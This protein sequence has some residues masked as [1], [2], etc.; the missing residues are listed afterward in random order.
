MVL[1]TI[2]VTEYYSYLYVKSERA[3]YT[4]VWGT[5][6]PFAT[7]KAEYH[8]LYKL[9]EGKKELIE[10][11]LTIREVPGWELTLK[12][13]YLT[14]LI[15]DGDMRLEP[16]YQ[17]MLCSQR[18]TIASIDSRSSRDTQD[19]YSLAAHRVKRGYKGWESISVAVQ[20]LTALPDGQP[21]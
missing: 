4:E 17:A 21:L 19:L 8:L 20:K 10:D 15:L 9:E 7:P 16:M 18:D 2:G 1:D 6:S 13:S 12:E 11:D 14:L 3:R 5:T